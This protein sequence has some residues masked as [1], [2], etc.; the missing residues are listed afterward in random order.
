MKK[1]LVTIEFRYCD[2]PNSHGN[3]YKT[4]V[5]TIGVY[6]TFADA[7]KHGN[8]LLETLESKFPLHVFPAGHKAAAACISCRSQGYRRCSCLCEE[9]SGTR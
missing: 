7:A 5:V 6:D 2:E 1:H 3:T 4:K 8:D 9:I